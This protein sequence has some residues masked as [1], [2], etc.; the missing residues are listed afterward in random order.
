MDEKEN[1]ERAGPADDGAALADWR[2]C[3]AL[4]LPN[5]DNKE[6]SVTDKEEIRRRDDYEEKWDSRAFGQINQR[7][8]R[9]GS[10]GGR[11]GHRKR[12]ADAE[13]RKRADVLQI[14]SARLRRD[15]RLSFKSPIGQNR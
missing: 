13:T 14:S 3:R 5:A 8:L 2:S 1:G 7:P 11:G 10:S 6:V 9:I 15:R 4:Q 12:R